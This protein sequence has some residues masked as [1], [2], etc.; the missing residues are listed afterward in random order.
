M[1]KVGWDVKMESRYIE[2]NSVWRFQNSFSS[3]SWMFQTENQPN[4]TFIWLRKC[5][6]V[7][8]LRFFCHIVLYYI[9][10]SVWAIPTYRVYW[11]YDTL[12]THN[13]QMNYKSSSL[14]SYLSSIPVVQ[15]NV[16]LDKL[17]SPTSIQE[18]HT[19]STV[20]PLGPKPIRIIIIIIVNC[21]MV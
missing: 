5:E 8:I 14:Q 2:N 17:T 4:I 15:I 1:T 21:S 9:Y 11:L 12:N 7:S 20:C 10:G 3:R 13:T 19:M 16:F 6:T 18:S